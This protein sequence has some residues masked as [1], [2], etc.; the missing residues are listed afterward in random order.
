M[1]PGPDVDEVCAAEKLVQRFGPDALDV[2]IS[3]EMLGHVRDWRA[4]I[5]NTKSVLKP[6]GTLLFTTRSQG[7]AFHA[8][9]FRLLAVRAIRWCEHFR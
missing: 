5:D 1:A 9:P 2:V 8:Y 7:F 6:G 4:V 3:T